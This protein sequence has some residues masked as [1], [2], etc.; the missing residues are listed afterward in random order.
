MN[1]QRT[2][3]GVEVQCTKERAAHQAGVEVQC[4][5]VGIRN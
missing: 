4:T 3:L 1:V 5:E 2:R